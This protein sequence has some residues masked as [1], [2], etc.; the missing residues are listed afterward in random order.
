[1][2]FRD[3]EIMSETDLGGA[4]KIMDNA[5]TSDGVE[6]AVRASPRRQSISRA[7]YGDLIQFI[8]FL[9]VTLSSICVAYFYHIEVLIVDF[10][11]Q[12]YAT[13]GIIGATGVTALL[14]RD[15][16]YEF[17]H[18]ISSSKAMRAV[19]A[20]WA[21]VVLGLIAF[22]FALKVSDSFSRFW[23]FTWTGVSVLTLLAARI[24]AGA[25]L[26][27]A[28][29]AGGVFRRRIAV[30]GANAVTAKFIR[31]AENPEL[32]VS[33]TGVFTSGGVDGDRTFKWPV[34]GNIASLE[35]AAR[36]GEVDDIVLALPNAE[37]DE[38]AAI[39]NRLSDLPVSVAILSSMHWLDH[40]GGEIVRIAGAPAL[41][42]YRRPLE[43]WG[44]VLKTVEDRVLG[45]VLFVVALPIMIAC[46]IALRTQGPGPLLF[47]Q[48]RHGFNHEVFR[49]YKFRTMT[50]AED[51]AVV[52]QAKRA[53]SR[54]T[55]VGRFLRKWSLDELPQL[56]NV[57]RGEMS[58]VG[59]RPHALAHNDEYSKLIENYSGRH[60]VK[61]GITG[62]AQV[63]GLR[64]ETSETKQMANRVRFDLEYIDN[65]SLW[66]DAKILVL[67]VAA[68]LFPKNAH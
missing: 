15:G 26:R 44:G 46:A 45:A 23:L 62:W 34:S 27:R 52:K 28:A 47:T 56:I 49:I 14:R 10:D 60:K 21:L 61:P 55:P 54:I 1:M 7:L 35:K 9:L 8:D 32:A 51:G 57:L 4:S 40:Q 6:A 43:G 20:R 42:L 16:Y 63:N 19:V 68:V 66:F 38:M 30:V 65:W 29:R 39:V 64:G 13:A 25:Y 18:L 22:A 50:V 3:G 67:T 17:E 31:Q 37:R 41:T 53:D 59:P 5:S 48:K 24:A 2:A 58:L 36:K 11:F 12:R 33:I